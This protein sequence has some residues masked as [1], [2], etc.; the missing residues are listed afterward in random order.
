MEI[1]Q[2]VTALLHGL[3]LNAKLVDLILLIAEPTELSTLLPAL[4]LVTQVGEELNATL[5]SELIPIAMDLLKEDLTI[6]LVDVFATLHGLVPLVTNVKDLLHTVKT[7][8]RLV[9]IV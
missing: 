1:A 2:D 3:E 4:A 6:P 5:A 7:E 9:Q 8:E